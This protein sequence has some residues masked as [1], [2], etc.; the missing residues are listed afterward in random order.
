MRV[1]LIVNPT[2]TGV[3]GPVLDAVVAQLERVCDLEVAETERAGHAVELAAE[4]GSGA[5]VGLGG[6]GTANEVANGVRPGVVVGVLPA[7]ASSVFARHL[8]FPR[9]TV[10]AGGMMAEAI[11]QESVKDVGLGLADDR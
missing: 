3:R 6:D 5:V 7:G 11:R 4:T 2:A 10:A 1:R 9:D 8:G